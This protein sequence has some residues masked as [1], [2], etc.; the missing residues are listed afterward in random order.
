MQSRAVRTWVPRFGRI[1]LSLGQ[2]QRAPRGR[3]PPRRLLI[4]CRDRDTWGRR[5][6]FGWL[7]AF[8]ATRS[9]ELVR[10]EALR[11]KPFPCGRHYVDS[12]RL[13]APTCADASTDDI[14]TLR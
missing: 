5:R 13:Q 2:H 8:E 1:G 11:D 3:L 14:E 10:T 6:P 9:A 4:Q 12:A 7:N